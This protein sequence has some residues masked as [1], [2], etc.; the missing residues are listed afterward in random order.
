VTQNP[1]RLDDALGRATLQ[2]F[3]DAAA[4]GIV[5]T[6]ETLRVCGWNR[7]MVA[8]TGIAEE[9]ALGRNLLELL[10]S[11]VE[12]GFDHHYADALNGA[13]TVLSYSLHRFIVP[14]RADDTRQGTAPQ[15]ARIGPLWEGARVIGT[16][17]TIDDV[18]ERVATE[19]ELRAQIAA[20]EAARKTAEAASRVKDEFLATLSHEIRTPLNAVLGWT[21]ILKSRALDLATVQRAVDVID[22]NASAQLTLVSDLLDMSRIATG[23]LRMDVAA[24]DL[25]PLTL[26]A[27]DVIRPAAE[28]KNVRI[29]TDLTTVPSVSGDADRLSQIIWNLLSNA[30]KFTDPGGTVTIA[31]NAEAG[32]VWLVIADTGQGI[33]AAFLPHVFERFK[34]ADSSTSRR[35]G[36]LGLGLALVREL[37]ELHG[38]TVHVASPGPGQGTTFTVV[39]PARL[40]VAAAAALPPSAVSDT[41]KTL[42]GIRVLVVEDEADAREILSRSIGEFGAEVTAVASSADAL[43]YLQEADVTTLPHIIVTDIGMPQQDGFGFL[44]ELRTLPPERGGILPAIAVTAYTGPMDRDRILSAGFKLHLEKPVSPGALASAI[45]R[46]AAGTG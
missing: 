31:L 27:I 26:A 23:K 5:T 13:V 7:W 20:S 10:P 24:V 43:G 41:E 3:R 8:A 22:R 36:G 38:G 32:Q 11:F 25:E 19:R 42:F 46:I 1:R 18:A 21:R 34:Q 6:D 14:G 39:L 9:A 40:E 33:D 37:V 29:A 44:R 16:I 17:T 45:A 30:V 35:H 4:Q 12:R 15:S 2:W 28:A